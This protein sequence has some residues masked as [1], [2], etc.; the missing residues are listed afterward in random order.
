MLNTLKRLVAA[1]VLFTFLLFKQGFS[2]NPGECGTPS[3]SSSS[4]NQ[5]FSS[6]CL[7]TGSDY[8]NKY[9]APQY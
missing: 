9:R 7:N 3:N 4:Y 1:L 8:I 5:M 6:T 2:Q